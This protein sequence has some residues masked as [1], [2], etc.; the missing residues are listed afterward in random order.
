[1]FLPG[2]RNERNAKTMT[3][4]K[5][6]ELVRRLLACVFALREEQTKSKNHDSNQPGRGEFLDERNERTKTQRAAIL[7]SGFMW[8][9]AGAVTLNQ[10]LGAP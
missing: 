9:C 1:M 8:L 2:E 6:R 7:H 10:I 4:P 3:R 5:V